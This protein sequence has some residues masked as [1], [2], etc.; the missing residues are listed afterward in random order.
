MLETLKKTV[1][2]A[3]LQ[4]VR[5]NL[6]IQT[7]GNVSGIDRSTNLVVIK[8]SGVSYDELNPEHMTVV[9]LETGKIV[10]GTLNPSSDTPTHLELYRAF[11]EIGGIVH[12]HS[13]YATAWA[14]ACR[15]IPPLG[16][17]HADYFHGPIPCS[18]PLT[19]QEIQTDYEINTGKV[20]IETFTK[21]PHQLDYKSIPAII[22]AE[23]GPFAWGPT[24]EKAV[25]NAVILEHLAKMATLTANI[26]PAI[27]PISQ[28][29]LDK[30]YLR[31]HG[32]NAY[33]GQS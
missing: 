31:K 14:Q 22:V 11:P 1:C 26:N 30:H 24:P 8:P 19:P 29:L 2:Q 18:R 27:C 9:S 16:T 33:Y 17:T 10:E 28:H 21:R 23:H 5:E 7:W 20:I 6:V 25:F 32:P 15:D 13:L 3:N 12:T 4:L